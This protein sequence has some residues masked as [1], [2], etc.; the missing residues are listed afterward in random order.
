MRREG[1]GEKATLAKESSH[2]FA[3]CGRSNQFTALSSFLPA[4][5]G[6]SL[7]LSRRENRG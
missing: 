1:E 6:I 5:G 7:S 3:M 4:S 2:F